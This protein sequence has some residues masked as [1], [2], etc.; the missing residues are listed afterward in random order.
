[1][2]R[3]VGA[4]TCGPVSALP[5]GTKAS[6]MSVSARVEGNKLP[7]LVDFNMNN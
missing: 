6:K 2:Y 1:M 3:L 5:R 7:T 4:I